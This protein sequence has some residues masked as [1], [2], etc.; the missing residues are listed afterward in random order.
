MCLR[1]S[2]MWTISQASQDKFR[3]LYKISDI[4]PFDDAVI[5]LVT[6]AQTALYLFNLLKKEY[7]DG[8]LCNDTQKAFGVFYREYHPVEIQ[9]VRRGCYFEKMIV[10]I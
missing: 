2:N 5:N 8:L 7:I 1:W 4:V 6:V 9:E 3:S 10:G